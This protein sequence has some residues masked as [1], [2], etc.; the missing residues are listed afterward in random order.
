QDVDL[1]F[2]K[3]LFR[4]PVS[5]T[6]L[7][8]VY[9]CYGI[10]V[11]SLPFLLF[12]FINRLFLEPFSQG[13]HYL[14]MFETMFI[15]LQ[16][17]SWLGGPAR[18]L[19][20]T[21]TLI[22]LFA[23]FHFIAG[24]KPA[25]SNSMVCTIIIVVSLLICFW[26]VSKDR[27]GAWIDEWQWL[28]SLPGMFQKRSSRQFKTA[29]E[30]QV[31]FEFR[32]AGYI[33]PVAAISIIIM[34]IG[35][36]LFYNGLPALPLLVP[37]IFVA[38]AVMA[39]ISGLILFT[40]YRQDKKSDASRFCLRLPITTQKL[41]A[42]R[43]HAMIQSLAWVTAIILTLSLSIAL[44]T[45]LSNGLLDL[46]QLS[47]IKWAFKYD[48]LPVILAM[49]LT[50]LFGFALIYWTLLRTAPLIA[51]FGFILFNIIR[52]TGKDG[53]FSC[54]GTALFIILMAYAAIVF[55]IA[56]RRDLIT[57]GTLI[58]CACI[59]ALMAISMLTFPFFTDNLLH[60]KNH[61]HTILIMICVG[62]LPV[63]PLATTPLW[64]ERFR[65]R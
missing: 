52:F 53:M 45:F 12:I 6:T 32:Q 63:M 64:I 50:G 5:T 51:L 57:F 55:F 1:A 39:A 11:L 37:V 18:Y 24:L 21:I 38:I 54:A 44:W 29:L 40:L 23:I 13:W 42:A 28:K 19:F 2:P 3:R 27:H 16:A 65:H 43:S 8:T 58:T 48:S 15:A 47:P 17:L 25:M 62:I 60:T 4:L 7:V 35:I 59:T 41:A 56:K 34:L 26:S 14:L 10:I 46:K 31:W 49:T 30:A 33:F 36:T 22:F 9:I 61:T 20:L